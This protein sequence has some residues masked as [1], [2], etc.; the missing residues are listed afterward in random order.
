[1][2][3]CSKCA[4]SFR[5]MHSSHKRSLHSVSFL[6]FKLLW[7]CSLWKLNCLCWWRRSYMNND[8]TERRKQISSVLQYIP[9]ERSCGS[10]SWGYH[11]SREQLLHPGRKGTAPFYTRLNP[12]TTLS[13]AQQCNRVNLLRRE[14]RTGRGQY[15][16]QSQA[17]GLSIRWIDHET[18]EPCFP[19][20][21]FMDKLSPFWPKQANQFVSART[22]RP[23]FSFF[24]AERENSGKSFVFFMWE[25]SPGQSASIPP[26]Q[27]SSIN[28]RPVIASITPHCSTA[29]PSPLLPLI[30]LNVS[31]LSDGNNQ[32]TAVPVNDEGELGPGQDRQRAEDEKTVEYTALSLISAVVCFIHI[33]NRY[34][35]MMKEL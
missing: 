19:F 29:P 10:V 33:K 2:S 3:S 18:G 9:P 15:R 6:I 20:F 14:A 21:P 13:A 4:L 22:S 24:H 17:F 27:T 12:F 31:E 16:T 25:C 23:S 8:S 1:M 7:S 34:N 30:C 26:P 5:L 11:Q 35:I 28:L 32:A